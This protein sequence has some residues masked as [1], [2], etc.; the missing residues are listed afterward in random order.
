MS[1]IVSAGHIQ[2]QIQ[3]HPEDPSYKPIREESFL[4]E[5]CERDRDP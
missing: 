2:G 4:E 3:G 1:V 5:C